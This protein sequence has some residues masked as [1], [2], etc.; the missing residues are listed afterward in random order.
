MSEGFMQ[1]V[2]SEREARAK[3]CFLARFTE[4]GQSLTKTEKIQINGLLQERGTKALYKH[5]ELMRMARELDC[6]I[7]LKNMCNDIIADL[8]LI[9]PDL[10]KLTTTDYRRF[11]M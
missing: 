5:A 9:D 1:F 2:A 11:E 4:H 6:S 7:G 3:L 8:L 10:A